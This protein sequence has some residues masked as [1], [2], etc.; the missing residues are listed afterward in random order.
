MLHPL[1]ST[2]A[3]EQGITASLCFQALFTA[4]AR[5]QPW[6]PSQ[7][8]TASSLWGVPGHQRKAAGGR[9]KRKK[10]RC[11]FTRMVSSGG[12]CCRVWCALK[13]YSGWEVNEMN[14]QWEIQWGLLI[15][16]RHELLWIGGVLLGSVMYVLTPSAV[17]ALRRRIM[18]YAVEHFFPACGARFL[19][20]FFTLDL[21]K[22]NIVL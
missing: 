10:R 12:P 17:A 8:N 13:I 9:I 15:T 2:L 16:H 11:F 1:K 14:S 4:R 7:H 6:V 5:I 21:G 18:G 20:L 19:G 3:L 22:A